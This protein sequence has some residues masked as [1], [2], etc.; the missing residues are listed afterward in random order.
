MCVFNFISMCKAREL[1]EEHDA[2]RE[3]LLSEVH[4]SLTSAMKQS[5]SKPLTLDELTSAIKAMT[6]G[7]ALGPNG[8]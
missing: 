3:I 6:K 1:N 7:K 8:L 2:A 5:L 4:S